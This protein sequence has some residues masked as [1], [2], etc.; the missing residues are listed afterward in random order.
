[1]TPRY[2]VRAAGIDGYAPA[3]HSGT[4]NRR[5]IGRETV[6]ATLVEVLVGTIVRGHGASRHAHPGLEQASLL[7]AGEGTAEEDGREFG[8]A[9]GN[10][11][12][13]ARGAFHRFVVSSAEPARVLVV[14]APPYSENPDAVVVDEGTSSAGRP[15]PDAQRAASST[16]STPAPPARGPRGWERGARLVERIGWETTRARSMQV[17]D[18]DLAGG[19]GCA[20]HRDEDAEQA[21]HVRSGELS[22][23]IDGDAVQALAGDWVFVPR[24][25]EWRCTAPAPA[26][27]LLVR[28][29]AA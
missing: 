16:Q 15:A 13:S 6:G 2:L 9:P 7:L 8:L 17:F 22:L 4:T 14:Y 11:V 20:A 24:G 19:V 1:M 28:G 25:A 26:S 23:T 21:L 18:V 10:W 29:L 3:N 5:L 27:V 12:F